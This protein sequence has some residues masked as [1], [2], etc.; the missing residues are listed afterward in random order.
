MKIGLV[1]LD[2]SHSEIFTRLLNNQDDPHHIQGATITHVIPTF[3]EDLAISSSRFTD[4]YQIV[5]KKYGVAEVD[6]VEEL[7]GEVDAVIIGTVDGRNH[8][9][10]FKEIVPYGKPVF[11]DKPVVMSSKEMAEV[12]RLSKEHATPVMS[13]SA[14]RFSESVMAVKGS[15][16]WSSGYF[17]GPTPMQEQLTG[18]FWYGIHLVEMAVTLFGTGVEKV[19]VEQKADCHHVHLTY[20]DGRHLIIRGETEWHSRFGAVLHSSDD[21]QTLKLW[22]EEKPFYAGLVE[23]M[24]TFFETGVGAVSLEETAEIVRIIEEINKGL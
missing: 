3:S 12:I 19:G 16:D 4:F 7:M 18:Y 1:G 17:Y 14:L 6:T 10:W 5:I 15:V 22:E 21:V 13:S 23:H 2:T 9:D 11:I 20:K 24:V 8:L